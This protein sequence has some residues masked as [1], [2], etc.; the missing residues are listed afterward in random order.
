MENHHIKK[1]L[2]NATL[3]KEMRV[4]RGLHCFSHLGSIKKGW[5]IF[6]RTASKRQFKQTHNLYLKGKKKE[7]I[8]DYLLKVTFPGW[9]KL[10][11]YFLMTT[12]FEPHHQE[13]CLMGWFHFLILCKYFCQQLTTALF[14][15]VEG[16][17]VARLG[18]GLATPGFAVIC[19]ANCKISQ[20]YHA[21]YHYLTYKHK[22]LYNSLDMAHIQR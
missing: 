6:V 10:A 20:Q 17:Y 1:T 4:F 14:G 11:F 7:Y 18:F 13:T 16:E 3:F 22:S 2:E 21:S 5:F 19:A 12:F 8:T 9:W 15:S